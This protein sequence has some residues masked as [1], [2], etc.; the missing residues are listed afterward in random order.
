MT[1]IPRADT[2]ALGTRGRLGLG[3]AIAVLV[4]VPLRPGAS[5]GSVDVG[6]ARDLLAELPVGLYERAS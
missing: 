5:K 3:A 1:P 2:G 6:G 4:V